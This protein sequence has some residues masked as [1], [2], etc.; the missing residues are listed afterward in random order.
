MNPKAPPTVS[1]IARMS[2]SKPKSIPKRCEREGCRCKI[3]LTDYECRC[4]HYYCSEH[5][6][7]EYHSCSFDY[8]QY[9]KEILLKTLSTPIIAEKVSVI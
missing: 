4:G 8:K 3:K 2:E 7:G 9:Q 6:L 1:R 5:R